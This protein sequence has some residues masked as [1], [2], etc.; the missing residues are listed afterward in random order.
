LWP[1]IEPSVY[2]EQNFGYEDTG[3]GPYKVYGTLDPEYTQLGQGRLGFV[4]PL[5]T[6]YEAAQAYDTSIGGS[7][8]AHIHKFIGT[9]QLYY[10]PMSQQAHGAQ[11][12]AT[13]PY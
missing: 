5:F 12:D 7:G 1:A 2:L 11:D 13:I 8:Q 9:P 3:T 6:T 10:M 4:Y